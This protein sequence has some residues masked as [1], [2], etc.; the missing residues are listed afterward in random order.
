VIERNVFMV[1]GAA[2]VAW[3]PTH[4]DPWAIV[5]GLAI[6]AVIGCLLAWAIER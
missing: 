3:N 1:L 5:L 6:G 2:A 4:G